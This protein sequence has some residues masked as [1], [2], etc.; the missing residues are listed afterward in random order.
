MP[1]SDPQIPASEPSA[2][3]GHAPDNPAWNKD[4]KAY[5][6]AVASEPIPE[7]FAALLAK[8]AKAIRK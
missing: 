5:Y 6:N 4:I 2:A 8:M 3:S 7:E 1:D